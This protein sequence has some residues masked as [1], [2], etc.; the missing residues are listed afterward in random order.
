[1]TALDYLNANVDSGLIVHYVSHG[2]PAGKDVAYHPQ[3]WDVPISG[4]EDLA[5]T[6]TDGEW[7]WNGD[8]SP[9]DCASNSVTRIAIY[10]DREEWDRQTAEYLAEEG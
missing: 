2:A 5:G 7:R 10:P 6:V 9:L 8:G 1:M 4:L 3:Y